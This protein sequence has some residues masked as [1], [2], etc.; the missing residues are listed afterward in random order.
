MSRCSILGGTTPRMDEML[1]VGDDLDNS[2]FMEDREG[3]KS[4]IEYD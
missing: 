2:C 4:Q 1:N 3:N